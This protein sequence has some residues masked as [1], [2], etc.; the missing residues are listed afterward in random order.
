MRTLYIALTLIA[1]M[2]LASPQAAADPPSPVP[3]LDGPT[4]ETSPCV[5][6]T[7]CPASFT[8]CFDATD[9]HSIVTWVRD[10]FGP[11]TCDPQPQPW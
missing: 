9:P 3:C 2:T 5:E 1:L 7:V 4:P 10:Q 6:D 8:G 11:C